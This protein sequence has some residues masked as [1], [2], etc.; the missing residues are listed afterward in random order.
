MTA[1]AIPASAAQA[2]RRRLDLSGAVTGMGLLVGKT[3]GRL[4]GGRFALRNVLSEPA[5]TA[6]L[7][8][9]T[10]TVGGV[11]LDSLGADVRLAGRS[12][13]VFSIGLR[14]DNGPTAHV[15]GSAFAT[16]GS[17]LSP[18]ALTRLVIDSSK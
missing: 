16:G 18:Q 12:Q 10:L 3:R 11:V 13:A 9:D 14:S 8:F 2:T 15:L 5:G 1:E 17:I 7:R 6:T 4:V